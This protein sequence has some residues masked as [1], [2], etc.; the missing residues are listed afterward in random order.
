[1]ADS[2]L[3]FYRA[4][5]KGCGGNNPALVTWHGCAISIHKHPGR[6]G[7]FM[8]CFHGNFTSYAATVPG[9]LPRIYE[10]C[11][12]RH[13]LIDRGGS[14][15]PYTSKAAFFAHTEADTNNPVDVESAAESYLT[16]FIIPN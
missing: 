4:K 11:N 16:H 5:W 1:M 12:S 2:G 7:G 3:K 8:I 14:R 6:G 10:H 9:I 15:P 13:G